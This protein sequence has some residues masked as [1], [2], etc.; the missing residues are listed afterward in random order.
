[1]ITTITT[2]ERTLGDVVSLDS[3]RARAS[4]RSVQLS[5]RERE[6]LVELALGRTTE[7]A[8]GTLFLSPHTVR[9]HV[10]AAMRKLGAR[11]R[12]H[13]VAIALTRG[14]IVMSDSEIT[15]VDGA[16]TTA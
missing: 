15:T 2:S 9:C 6:V 4:G 11:T 10:K 13:A 7:E 5:A 3:V 8:A 1:M 12:P 16:V 14:A